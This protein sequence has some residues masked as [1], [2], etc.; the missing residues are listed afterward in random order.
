MTYLFLVTIG[1]VQEFIAGARRTRDLWFGSW[2]LSELSREAAQ[3]IHAPD[4]GR[5]LIFPSATTDLTNRERQI[6]NRVIAAIDAEPDATLLGAQVEQAVQQR[7]FAIRDRAFAM[8]QI[9]WD[10]EARD[11]AIL[12]E[13]A[14]RQV[15][16]LIEVSWVA[17]PL[18]NNYA[19]SRVRLEDLMAA[20]K[21]TRLFPPS[22]CPPDL[23]QPKS[24]ID[25][26]RESVIPENVYPH[27]TDA[28]AARER[29]ANSLFQRYGA[30]RA[31]RLSGVDLLKRH[32]RVD[33]VSNQIGNLADF[34]STSHFA[35]LP[36]LGRVRD[37]RTLDLAREQ[38]IRALEA[39][40]M[41]IERLAPRYRQLD[42]FGMFDASLL[43]DERLAE[44]VDQTRIPAAQAAL[45]AFYTQLASGRPEPYYALLHADGDN[46]G[47]VI[48][49]QGNAETHRELSAALDGFASSVRKIV[50]A[51]HAGALVYAGGDDVLAFLPLDTALGCAKQL[52]D[53]FTA[54]LHGYRGASAER[55]TLSVGL[56]ICHHVEPLSDALNL[57][58][59]AEKAAK[60]IANKNGLA[61]TLSKRSGADRTISGSWASGFFDRL[62]QLTTFHQAEAIP[63]GTA[64]DL[65]SLTERLGQGGNH[66]DPAMLKFE[67]LRIVGRKR[68]LRGAAEQKNADLVKLAN[69]LPTTASEVQTT[70]WSVAA[71]A[72]EIIVA[73]EFARALGPQPKGAR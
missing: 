67:A 32:G 10:D 18:T 55:A 13:L 33:A 37:R 24:S 65:R 15:A 42:R 34:P 38:Y 25:G 20:R 4:A 2:L 23:R 57:A 31:E 63:D 9:D 69:A 58:R 51:A 5:Q 49:N 59:S 72:E 43:F 22:A 29:K 8:R 56:A 11:A 30:G 61:I 52:A 47:K 70:G 17:T 16:E 12:R 27:R 66:P 71:F 50:E 54:A 53:T 7:L 45:H 62:T 28:H 14:D 1:P 26:A 39:L 3:T 44:E 64:Y 46:M 40:G 41:Q 6:V 48:D 36:F 73:R 35:A 60:R 19:S 68:G 21:A